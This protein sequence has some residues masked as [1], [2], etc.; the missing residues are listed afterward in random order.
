MWIVLIR[1]KSL[2]SI[3]RFKSTNVQGEQTRYNPLNFHTVSNSYALTVACLSISIIRC[4]SSFYWP[5]WRTLVYVCYLCSREI[6]GNSINIEI[7]I[8]KFINR[9]NI[10]LHLFLRRFY[11]IINQPYN[12]DKNILFYS[13][14][15]AILQPFVEYHHKFTI[16]LFKIFLIMIESR[17]FVYL[18]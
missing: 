8:Y 17:W 12:Y 14:L 16:N 1:L 9:F 11:T 13:I 4:A 7:F 18:L 6:P 2:H 3:H 15:N 10:F 5:L